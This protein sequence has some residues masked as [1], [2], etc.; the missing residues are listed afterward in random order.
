MFSR[1]Q[2]T[3]HDALKRYDYWDNDNGEEYELLPVAQNH[4]QVVSVHI[5]DTES[6]PPLRACKLTK[7]H[8]RMRM[9]GS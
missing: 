8:S 2:Y 9:G 6:C 3:L 4:F 5:T 1:S 7:A